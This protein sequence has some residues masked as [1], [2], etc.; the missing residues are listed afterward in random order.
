MQHPL[1]KAKSAPTCFFEF[2]KTGLKPKCPRSESFVWKPRVVNSIL[3]TPKNLER[4][5]QHTFNINP[6]NQVAIQCQLFGGRSNKWKKKV[7][8]LLFIKWAPSKVRHIFWSEWFSLQALTRKECQLS[9]YW[10]T[11]HIQNKLHCL[12]NNLSSGTYIFTFNIL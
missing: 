12:Y 4:F 1:L 9:A 2:L 5:H 8:N 3:V 11:T 7:Y 6:L 10:M